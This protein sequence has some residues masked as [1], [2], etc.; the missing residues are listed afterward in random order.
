MDTAPSLVAL[1]ENYMHPHGF[2]VLV[3]I[4]LVYIMFL[5]SLCVRDVSSVFV[6]IRSLYFF[7]SPVLSVVVVVLSVWL[8]DVLVRV[9]VEYRGEPVSGVEVRFD[10][11][12]MYDITGSTGVLVFP[13]KKRKLPLAQEMSVVKKG[14]EVNHISYNKVRKMFTVMLRSAFSH[15]AFRSP[16]GLVDVAREDAVS[17]DL[18]MYDVD[19]GVYCTDPSGSSVELSA[20]NKMIDFDRSKLFCGYSASVPFDYFAKNLYS[21]DITFKYR[22]EPPESVSFQ[23]CKYISA[24]SLFKTYCHKDYRSNSLCLEK[25]ELLFKFNKSVPYIFVDVPCSIYKDKNNVIRIYFRFYDEESSFVMVLDKS[26]RIVVRDSGSK[27]IKIQKSI[28]SNYKAPWK[29]VVVKNLANN[30][31]VDD[32]VVLTL[33]TDPVGVES[34]NDIVRVR[35]SLQYVPKGFTG[36]IHIPLNVGSFR[37]SPHAS[38][39]VRVGGMRYS[40][41]TTRGLAICGVQVLTPNAL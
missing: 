26:Y 25:D 37:F 24:D 36:A 17:V 40:R 14:F 4:V 13:V 11:L 12:D 18:V 2:V 7:L 39:D 28:N 15:S 9:Y 21:H 34:Q 8:N 27:T 38:F 32:D 3:L 41:Q 31:T 35:S 10:S 16:E 19:G 29:N 23:F 5:A 6:R 1:I 30:F 22:S 20:D 33:A